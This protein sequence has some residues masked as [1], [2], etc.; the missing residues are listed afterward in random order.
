MS[1]ILASKT[2]DQVMFQ[3]LVFPAHQT[4]LKSL[5]EPAVCYVCN[6]GLDSGHSITAK[7]ISQKIRFF[8]DIHF[9]AC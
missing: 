7:Y 1:Q 3:E 5:A 9:P 8:C 4:N 2:K 6:K